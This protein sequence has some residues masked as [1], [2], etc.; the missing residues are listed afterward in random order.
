MTLIIVLQLVV[1]THET[2]NNTSHCPRQPGQGRG[3]GG[4]SILHYS[5]SKDRKE[6]G[7]VLVTPGGLTLGGYAAALR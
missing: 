5:H 2:Q 4:C 7:G 1:M 6:A 3:V